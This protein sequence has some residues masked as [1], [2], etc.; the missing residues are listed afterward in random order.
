MFVILAMAML[1]MAS[2]AVR[3]PVLHGRDAES[4]GLLMTFEWFDETSFGMVSAPGLLA[5][6]LSLIV[7]LVGGLV[8]AF[9]V[10]SREP[11]SA[12]GYHLVMP[13]S[14]FGH[15]LARVAA[16]ASW[17]LIGIFVMLAAVIIGLVI[18]G[19]GSVLGVIATT[20]WVN[21]V[22]APLTV[23]LLISIVTILSN[24]PGRMLLIVYLTLIGPYV[25]A[26]LLDIDPLFRIFDVFVGGKYG[27]SVAFTHGFFPNLSV[28]GGETG[29]GEWLVSATIWLVVVGVGVVVAASRHRET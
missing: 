20:G 17:L 11:P 23:Y 19:R 6:T 12:R 13:I 10:W 24:H 25:L 28:S 2:F 3:I 14:R 26:A 27:Y 15:N 1:I 9:A 18:S 29:A 5:V 16:G 21:Y 22:V 4:G 8:W 7:M